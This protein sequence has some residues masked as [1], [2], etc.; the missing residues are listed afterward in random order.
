MIT[1]VTSRTK[2]YSLGSGASQF[3][4]VGSKGGRHVKVIKPSVKEENK[5]AVRSESD[6][7]KTVIAISLIIMGII[8]LFIFIGGGVVAFPPSLVFFGLLL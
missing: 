5:N 2:D 6:V 8:A 1:P 7:E 3:N 4:K